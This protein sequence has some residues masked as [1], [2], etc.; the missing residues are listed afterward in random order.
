M[1]VKAYVFLSLLQ[2]A[3]VFLAPLNI[4]GKDLVTPFYVFTGMLQ[5]VHSF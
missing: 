3:D 1:V 5:L 4:I 2:I